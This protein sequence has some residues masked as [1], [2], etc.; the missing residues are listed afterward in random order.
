M[1][2]GIDRVTGQVLTGWA[3]CVQ[4]IAVILTTRIGTR[5]MRRA[6]GSELKALQDRNATAANIAKVYVAIADAL[7]RW[8]PGFR[9]RT[10]RLVRGGPDG[11]FA[12]VLQGEFFPRGHLGDYTTRE[13]R[14]AAFGLART[15]NG[16]LIY[17]RAA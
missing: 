11:V 8:E 16:R 14:S 15:D 6:F 10:M 12:F 2:T 1:R 4:S 3:H 17:A 9:L 5:V 7:R 13:E